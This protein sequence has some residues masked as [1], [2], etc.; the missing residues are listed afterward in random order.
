M[1]ATRSTAS[2]EFSGNAHRTTLRPTYRSG[3]AASTPL[4]SRPAIGWPGTNWLIRSPSA[5]RA[6]ATTSDLVLPA[7]V[8]MVAGS[9]NGAIRSSSGWVCA[10]GAASS[11]KSA[12]DSAA[13]SAASSASEAVA[14]ITPSSSARAV[15][16][17]ERPTPITVREPAA[18]PRSRSARASEPPI[19]P[20]PK[21]TSLLK[22]NP[23]TSITQK[24]AP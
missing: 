12:P 10:T 22:E 16:A 24:S 2:G 15:D 17:D 5:A 1:A 7:S 20:T 23:A 14:S 13:R 21:I 8:T 18:S 3:K 9:R 6:A 4:D 11:T 19:R